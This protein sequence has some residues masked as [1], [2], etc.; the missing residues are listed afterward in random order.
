LAAEKVDA[1]F[2]AD[3]IDAERCEETNKIYSLWDAYVCADLVT[4]PSL[5]EGWGNQFI[6]AVFARK[7]IVLFEYPVFKFDIAREGY[8]YISLGNQVESINKN[9]LVVLPKKSHVGAVDKTIGM[10]L[11]DETVSLLDK[12]FAIGKQYHGFQVMEKFL[13]DFINKI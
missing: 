5:S 3:I 9:G 6:E 10:L 7:P 2:A 1:V 11:S 8:S 4:Y 12:N 13:E